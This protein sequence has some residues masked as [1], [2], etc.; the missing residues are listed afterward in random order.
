MVPVQKLDKQWLCGWLGEVPKDWQKV[1]VTP[2]FK[3]DWMEDLGNCWLVGF[4]T[5]P[6]KMMKQLIMEAFSKHMKDKRVVGSIQQGFMKGKL[7]FTNLKAFCNEIG[8]LVDEGRAVD[9]VY[10]VKSLAGASICPNSLSDNW[11]S[12]GYINVQ[13]GEWKTGWSDKLTM[14]WWVS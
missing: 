11:W 10:F 14:L 7:C 3:Q 1:S 6:G 13:W 5:V 4:L 8:W 2:V 9:F 12:T